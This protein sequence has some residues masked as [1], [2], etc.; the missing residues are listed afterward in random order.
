MNTYVSLPVTQMDAPAALEGCGQVVIQKRNLGRQNCNLLALATC[1]AHCP[2][3][4]TVASQH[5][6]HSSFF[7]NGCMAAVDVSAQL[8]FHFLFFCWSCG[9][10]GASSICGDV[11]GLNS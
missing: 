7:L 5:W 4:A 3:A 10:S 8:G 1:E 11:E 2:K 9:L 6:N